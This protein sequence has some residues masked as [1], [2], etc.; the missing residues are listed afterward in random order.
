MGQPLRYSDI[1]AEARAIATAA[2]R[3]GDSPEQTARA[4]I[5]AAE[6]FLSK[7]V[8]EVGL[9]EQ[10]AAIECGAGCYQC[11]HQMV[12]VTAAELALVRRAVDALPEPVRGQTRARIAHVAEHGKNLDQ[13]GWWQARLRCA[14]LDDDGRCLVHEARPLPCRAM[15]SS[16]AESCRRSFDG[17]KLQI[18]VL[19]AQHRVH[20]HAQMGLAEALAACG[21]ETRVFA[22]GKALA[23]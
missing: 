1:Q 12:A 17:E 15:N 14:L 16:S 20:G 6:A 21:A 19:T 22:L 9:H 23:D 4:V 2:L 3:R 18:P 10:M 7:V 13:A 5:D 11:C 8:A